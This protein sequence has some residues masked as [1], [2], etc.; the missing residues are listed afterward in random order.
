MSLCASDEAPNKERTK[1]FK[2]NK[3]EAKLIDYC[4]GD[5]GSVPEECFCLPYYSM[6]K[7]NCVLNSCLNKKNKELTAA[8]LPDGSCYT[9]P[10]YGFS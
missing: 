3:K 1:C 2:V 9:G 8:L 6:K 4:T 7:G 10:K 5:Q